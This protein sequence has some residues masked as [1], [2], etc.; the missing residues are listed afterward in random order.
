MPCE[1]VKYSVESLAYDKSSSL[2]IGPHPAEDDEYIGMFFMYATT[3]VKVI[4]EELLISFS[5]FVSSIGGN[6]G[7]F[8]GFS[9]FGVFSWAY[10]LIKGVLLT[11]KD[12]V[13]EK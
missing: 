1:H 6:L 12:T 4:K 8:I 10:D 9:C 11:K 2:S 7:M 5:N 3:E 13:E